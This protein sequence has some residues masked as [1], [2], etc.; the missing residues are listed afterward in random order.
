[1]NLKMSS[2]ER[3]IPIETPQ[4]E[5]SPSIVPG[6]KRQ[7][8][9]VRDWIKKYVVFPEKSDHKTGEVLSAYCELCRSIVEKQMLMK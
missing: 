1:M 2:I 9:F 8:G 7:N 5:P 3:P 4:G 6:K